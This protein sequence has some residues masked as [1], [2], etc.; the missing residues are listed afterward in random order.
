MDDVAEKYVDDDSEKE[1]RGT[2]KSSA[3][4]HGKF[5][6]VRYFNGEGTI[7]IPNDAMNLSKSD[8]SICGWIK[9]ESH[10][11]PWTIFAVQKG[12]GCYSKP[13][14]AGSTSGWDIGHGFFDNGTRLCIWDNLNNSGDEVINHNDGFR[15]SR[16]L[17]KWTHYVVVFNRFNGTTFIYINGPKQNQF[18]DISAI[19]GVINNDQPLRF[20]Y[21]HGWKTKGFLD[22]YKMYNKAL[23]DNEVPIIYN[24]HRV[25]KYLKLYEL[26]KPSN[27]SIL[28]EKN[29]CLY[30]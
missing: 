26:Y 21:V 9:I 18:I 24:D 19:T 11:Y 3:I 20:G 2:A 17:K 14:R 15:N 30:E 22:D 7:E 23:I 29:R 8:F 28:R 10:L 6:R 27:I 25:W 5:T 1:M 12:L 4:T 16:L 13:D